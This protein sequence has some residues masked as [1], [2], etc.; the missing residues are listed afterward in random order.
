MWN[1]LQVPPKIA[2]IP[3]EGLRIAAENLKTIAEQCALE[4]ASDNAKRIRSQ[5]YSQVLVTRAYPLEWFKDAVKEKLKNYGT[6]KGP[7]GS[8]LQDCDSYAVRAQ[9]AGYPLHNSKV[10]EAFAEFLMSLH[11]SGFAGEDTNGTTI[12]NYKGDWGGFFNFKDLPN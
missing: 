7:V 4:E 5:Y 8:A 2:A 10:Q 11:T 9:S 6:L 1:I 3:K 12:G